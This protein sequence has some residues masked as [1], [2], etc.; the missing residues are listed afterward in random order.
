MFAYHPFIKNK[1]LPIFVANF[2]L[3]EYGLGA[4]FGCP[5]HDQRDLD[6]AREY[7]IEV[8]PVVKPININEDY[9]KIENNAFTDPGIIINSEFLNG[10]ETEKGKEKIIAELE[11]K[12]ILIPN[13]IQKNSN[14][15]KRVKTSILAHGL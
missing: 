4:I 5:A 13:S 14:C 15:S 12:N 10:L 11:K 2:V 6:F 9:F 7:N 3:K 1:K 8:I